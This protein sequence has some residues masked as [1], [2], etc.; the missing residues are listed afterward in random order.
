MLRTIVGV[1]LLLATTFSY[2][3]EFEFE[4]IEGNPHRLV[5][6]RGKWVLVNFRATWCP[7]CL[8]EMP[9][10]NSLYNAHKDK[11]I[12]VI[13]VAMQ[14]GSKAVVSRFVDAHHIDY[15]IVT[16]TLKSAAQ[17][18]V[19]DALPV[20]YLYSPTGEQVISHVG[21]VT[22]DSIESYIRSRTR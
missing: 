15:P 6:Y 7:P 20:S 21:E 11:N 18:G 8:N 3:A 1:L 13:G 12:V 14:S 10:L 2:A 16:G 22:R 5:D 4:D 9:E 19:I 17:V